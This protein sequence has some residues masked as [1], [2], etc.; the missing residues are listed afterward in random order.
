MNNKIIDNKYFLFEKNQIN[1]RLKVIKFSLNIEFFLADKLSSLMKN[2]SINVEIKNIEDLKKV[3]D[4]NFIKLEKENSK[5]KPTD[6]SNLEWKKSNKLVDQ[7]I[8]LFKKVTP[9]I[10]VKK[11]FYD[12]SFG[13][14]ILFLK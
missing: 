10:T 11:Y 8:D 2:K 5:N 14:K 4:R 9:S 1:K 3:I 13:K 6:L 12:L 7:E